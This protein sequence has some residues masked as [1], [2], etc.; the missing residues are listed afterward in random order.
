MMRAVFAMTLAAAAWLAGSHPAAAY[1]VGA[2]LTLDQ[3]IAEADFVGKVTV[4][5]SAPAANP[6]FEH[7][8]GYEQVQ[9]Q[10]KVVATYKGQAGGAEIAFQHYGVAAGPA[11]PGYMPQTYRFERGRTYVVFA[12]ATGK[13]GVFRQ[14]WKSHNVQEDQG[15]VLAAGTEPRTGQPIK[16]VVF[17][18]LSG[19][20]QSPRAADVKYGLAHLDLLSGGAYGYGG[21]QDFDRE[22]VLGHVTSLLSHPDN[23]VVVSAINVM[24]SSNPYMS[25]EYAPHWLATIGEGPPGFA[26]WDRARVNLG[27]KLYWREL[28]AIVDGSAPAATRALAIRALGRADEYSTETMSTV[29]P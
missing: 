23:D 4:I 26:R 27:G 10:L 9:T 11:N 15:V 18:E 21:Q 29:A 14:L 25:A 24:G 28:A 2:S 19:L 7:V 20:L 17:A 12:A 13:P 1:I 22:D 8:Q 16:D 5:E 6:W 3:L